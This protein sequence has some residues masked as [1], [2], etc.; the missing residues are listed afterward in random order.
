[1]SGQAGA[2]LVDH[3]AELFRVD[4]VQHHGELFEEILDLERRFRLRLRDDVAAAEYGPRGRHRKQVDELL[5]DRALELDLRARAVLGD[6]PLAVDDHFDLDRVARERHTADPAD[7]YAAVR[8]LLVRGDAAGRREDAVDVVRAPEHRRQ[9]LDGE[10]DHEGRR[11]H[12]ERGRVDDESPVE[13][14]RVGPHSRS[15][16]VGAFDAAG[17]LPTAGALR[18]S[19]ADPVPGGPVFVRDKTTSSCR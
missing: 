15:A 12:E 11:K 13:P 16:R 18:E 7:L 6:L 2:E 19:A 8:H 4:R 10:Q 1:M 17:A 14:H 9:H 3:R 5:A